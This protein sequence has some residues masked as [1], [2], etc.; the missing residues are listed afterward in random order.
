VEEMKLSKH[1]FQDF[2]NKLQ[3]YVQG[4]CPVVFEDLFEDYDDGN[5]DG[6][7]LIGEFQ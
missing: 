2:R 6:K 7:D 4:Y 1:H 3:T 5:E